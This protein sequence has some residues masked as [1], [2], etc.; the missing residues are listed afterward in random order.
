MSDREIV[1]IAIGGFGVLAATQWANGLSQFEVENS[2]CVFHELPGAVNNKHSGSSKA[3]RAVFLD[4][5]YRS[6]IKEDIGRVERVDE[7]LHST[8]DVNSKLD[9]LNIFGSK[10][11]CV[12][13]KKK[14]VRNNQSKG[15][16]DDD[17]E[18]D[19]DDLHGGWP[20]KSANAL[21][22]R[23]N[24][25]EDDEEE[26][27]DNDDDDD[28]DDESKKLNE[29]NEESDEDDEYDHDGKTYSES[30]KVARSIQKETRQPPTRNQTHH[31]WW[32]Y[33]TAPHRKDLDRVVSFI[34]LPNATDTGGWSQL[35]SFGFGYNDNTVRNYLEN[36]DKLAFLDNIRRELE[37]CDR[38]QGIQLFVDSDSV[39]GGIGTYVASHILGD[40][41][42]F[43][44]T[45][46]ISCFPDAGD[47]ELDRL[48]AGR[49]K[50]QEAASSLG[51]FGASRNELPEAI[52]LLLEDNRNLNRG[53]ATSLLSE[54]TACYVPHEIHSWDQIMRAFDDPRT[55]PG[56]RTDDDIAAASIVAT[57][58][59][60]ILMPCRGVTSTVARE[61]VSRDSTTTASSTQ[62]QQQQ[63]MAPPD[64]ICIAGA[65]LESCS[66]NFTAA[67]FMELLRPSSS[68]RL[69][70]AYLALP[71]LRAD[72]ASTMFGVTT[73]QDGGEGEDCREKP[74][75]VR[76]VLFNVLQSSAPLV[77]Q[78]NKG[79]FRPLSGVIVDSS[80][81]ETEAHQIV[82]HSY[83][84][85]A[86]LPW[87][88][89]GEDRR[90]FMREALVDYT[91][92]LRC[93]NFV[94]YAVRE[95]VPLSA[96]FPKRIFAPLIEQS[97]KE[98]AKTTAHKL[99]TIRTVSSGAHALTTH[100]AGA[101]LKQ[102]HQNALRKNMNLRGDARAREVMCVD[103]DSWRELEED[104]AALTDNYYFEGPD[105][106]REVSD[107]D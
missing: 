9:I 26:E 102:V 28:D 49:R 24:Y 84:I 79:A 5:A 13:H 67:Q 101:Y 45:M 54:A 86:G 90:K 99:H 71:F 17:D 22:A 70:T 73:S 83:T 32:Q 12:Q 61:I 4:Q 3:V 57:W 35:R 41:F 85:R 51:D 19:D 8:L 69:Q 33:L 53:F 76:E 60:S 89:D 46:A 23:G 2:N 15:G 78:G 77:H 39:F 11:R 18:D 100:S 94:G 95:P 58:Q 105:D 87:L 48:A 106:E 40:E 1:T 29:K 36:S 104:L 21:W 62:Q 25:Y 37:C 20:R 14:N 81:L 91:M 10:K 34:D 75:S 72:P 7:E 103:G 98:G 96:T 68:M 107:E 38:L 64:T 93:P 82:A 66:T 59:D 80:K 88:G 50:Q 97:D 16:D 6:S 56:L 74:K 30:E 42:G 65:Q 63:H 47:K 44:R 55:L 31:P 92:R 43:K 27:E 52:D